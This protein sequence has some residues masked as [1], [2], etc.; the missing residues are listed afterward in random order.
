MC[1]VHDIPQLVSLRGQHEYLRSVE[2]VHSETVHSCDVSF[3]TVHL[4][5]LGSFCG[6]LLL[7]CR[8]VRPHYV[9]GDLRVNSQG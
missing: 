8:D 4:V 5:R 1:S 6:V 9:K 3:I 2:D 7:S